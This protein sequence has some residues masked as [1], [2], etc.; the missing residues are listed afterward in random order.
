M[1]I[2]YVSN[3][4]C[5]CKDG[6]TPETAWATIAK[7]NE[8]IK[9]GDVVKFRCGDTFYGRLQP[10]AG[11]D[12]DHRTTYESYGEGKKPVVSQYKIIKPEAWV[13]TDKNVWRVDL[14][15][16]ANFTGNVT[17]INNNIGF[18]KI[19]GKIYGKKV[20]KLEDLDTQ[21]DFYN[22]DEGKCYAWVK[23]EKNPA[24]LA[25][26][27]KLACCIGCV[28][29]TDNLAVHGIVF[30]GTG[31]HGISG[32][33]H[34][35]HIADCE[36]HEIGG[37]R[38][39]GYPNPTTRYGNGVETWA[40]SNNVTVERCRFSEIYDVAITMQGR[41]V[42]TS[43]VNMYF[44]NNVMWNCLQCFEI[45]S[46]G[47][48]PDTGF[49]NCHFEGNT[50]IDTGYCWA[51]D[52]RPNKQVSVPLLLY[53]LQCPLCDITVAHNTFSRSKIATIFKSDGVPAFPKD[54]KIYDNIIIRDAG[55]DIIYRDKSTSDEDYAAFLKMIE[56]NNDVRDTMFY[57]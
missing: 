21:W 19:D 56:D 38:L 46:S 15:D 25:K 39:I 31:G 1:S 13:E 6:L 17:N 7:V 20:F 35:A 45:W 10:P 22:D 36:F 57:E 48:V 27:I 14:S 47:D 50:C 23:S 49:V 55:Q 26:E 2:Y 33:T 34:Y 32:V 4:G 3:N 29:F 16:T 30:N 40:N 24:E 52:V 54:Y 37:S 28:G 42:K 41:P 12:P 5:D 18:M 11:I 44:I 53:G 43:W 51:Y 9:G 8:T